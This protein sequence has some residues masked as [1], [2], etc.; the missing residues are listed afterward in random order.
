MDNW[1]STIHILYIIYF[2][3]NVAWYVQL[4][5]SVLINTKL[6]YKN[7]FESVGNFSSD[8]MVALLKNKDLFQDSQSNFI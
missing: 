6:L 5:S 4:D 1:E 7:H 8:P 2:L 3:L